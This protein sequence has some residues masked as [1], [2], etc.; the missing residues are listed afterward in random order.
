MICK[1]P[2]LKNPYFIL[3]KIKY[4]TISLFKEFLATY[5]RRNV[6]QIANLDRLL[7]LLYY[8]RELM[9]LNGKII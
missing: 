7:F 8:F 4:Y 2:D 3:L 9:P 5:L 1:R 6:L